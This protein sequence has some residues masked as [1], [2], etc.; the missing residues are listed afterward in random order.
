MLILLILAARVN[1]LSIADPRWSHPGLRE[2]APCLITIG[3][4]SWDMVFSSPQDV[5]VRDMDGSKA[6]LDQTIALLLEWTFSSLAYNN[7]SD[8]LRRPAYPHRICRPLFERRHIRR[9][10][11]SWSTAH[12]REFHD[13]HGNKAGSLHKWLCIRARAGWSSWCILYTMALRLW[14]WRFW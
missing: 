7:G 11:G 5:W 2:G 1:C 9:A 10:G 3:N 12:L 6:F 8:I 4:W 14:L 13:V